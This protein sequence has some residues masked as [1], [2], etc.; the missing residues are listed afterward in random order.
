MKGNDFSSASLIATEGVDVGWDA[1]DSVKLLGSGV[2]RS[3]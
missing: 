3:L 1:V 2:R